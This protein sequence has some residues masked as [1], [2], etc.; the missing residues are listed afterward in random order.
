M[1]EKSRVW[2]ASAK[3]YIKKGKRNK[4]EN[5]EQQ[6]RCIVMNCVL[7]EKNIYEGGCWIN[8]NMCIREV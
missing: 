1:D 3:A 7:G 8:D 6:R 4:K 2:V 5:M